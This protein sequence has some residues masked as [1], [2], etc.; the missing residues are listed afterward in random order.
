M[1]MLDHNGIDT[2]TKEEVDTTY[3][4]AVAQSEN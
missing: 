1:S 4:M 3:A 2:S